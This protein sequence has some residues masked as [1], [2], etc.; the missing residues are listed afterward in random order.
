MNFNMREYW[1][2][3]K[4]HREALTEPFPYMVSIDNRLHGTVGGVVMQV[5]RQDAARLLA[6]GTHRLATPEEVAAHL[7]TQEQLRVEI[8]QKER[9]RRMLVLLQPEE[10]RPAAVP[11][12]AKGDK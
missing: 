4:Q 8:L 3:V 5:A 9:E 1:A 2:A 10:Q 11:V 6:D 12:K 7:E